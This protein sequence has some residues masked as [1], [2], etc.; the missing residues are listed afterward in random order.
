MFFGA[1]PSHAS[2][3]PDA[4]QKILSVVLFNAASVME[5]GQLYRELRRH[6]QNLEVLVEERT[7]ELRNSQEAALAASKAKSEFLANMSHEIRT[8]IN[9]IVGMNSL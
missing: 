6:T 1:L 4:A 7:Q 3:V 8:P 2:F 5:S 9:G